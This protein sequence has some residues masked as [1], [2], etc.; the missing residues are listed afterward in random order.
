MVSQM[1]IMLPFNRYVGRTFVKAAGK[2]REIL[3]RLNE[4]AGFSPNQEIDLYEVGFFLSSSV[5]FMGI[6]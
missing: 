2:P 3:E 6:V 5:P 4:M 1:S